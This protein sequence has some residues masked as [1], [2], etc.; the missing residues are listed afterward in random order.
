MKYNVLGNSNL[1]VSAISLGVWQLGDPKY[2]GKVEDVEGTIQVALDEGINLFD[3]AE[4]YGNGKSEEALGKALGSNRDRVIIASKVSE[5]KLSADDLPTACEES[6]ARL[7]TD[8]IDLYQVHWPTETS[9]PFEETYGAMTT[10]QQQGKIRHIGVSNFGRRDLAKWFNTGTAVSNQLGYN[11]LFRATEY[12]IIPTCQEHG[13]SVLAYMPLMQ[14]L[15]TG[16]WKIVEE[17]PPSR[18]RTRHFSND[19]ELTRH[20]EPGQEALTMQTIDDLCSLAEETG[21][22]VADMTVGWL[23]KQS[24]V[25]SVICG[26][27]RP[28]QVRRNA[29]TANI[30]L[31]NDLVSR[32]NEITRP[33]KE[34]LGPNA[35]MWNN[36]EESRIS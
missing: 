33:L 2:W 11:L 9:V 21:I 8:R 20:G 28:D 12:E 34:A 29:A 17:I 26:A 10:L 4:I 1:E 3:T 24:Q 23:I 31:P 18:R 14:G 22:P 36:Q 19:R 35:D 5:S 15:L 30:E 25:A 16:R 13:L 32:L 27:T 7:G 6:L